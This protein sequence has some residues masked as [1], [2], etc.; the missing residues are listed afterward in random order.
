MADSIFSRKRTDKFQKAYEIIQATPVQSQ[1][2]EIRSFVTK[3]HEIWWLSPETPVSDISVARERWQLLKDRDLNEST[4]VL[5]KFQKQMTP[6][7]FSSLTTYLENKDFHSTNNSAER[8]ARRIKKIQK[9]R[10]RIRAAK[11]MED[12]ILLNEL[13]RRP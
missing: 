13:S 7:L 8:Y 3:W 4:K 11:H 6:E 5:T 1:L 2:D 12:H 9:S 10:Y